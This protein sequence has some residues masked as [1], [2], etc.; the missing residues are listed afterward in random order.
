AR[1][2]PGVPAV[3]RALRDAGL[4]AGGLSGRARAGGRGARGTPRGARGPVNRLWQRY[5]GAGLVE[6]EN[7]FGTQGA[8]PTHPELLDWLAVEFMERG[9]G[10]KAMHRLIVTSATYRQASR[11]RADLAEVDPHNKLLGRQARLRLPARVAPGP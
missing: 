2:A 8:L 7:D 1:G 6:T 3:R 11:A 4:Q 10:L 5:F 9:W